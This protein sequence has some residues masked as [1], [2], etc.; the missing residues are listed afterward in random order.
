ME[1]VICGDVGF[2]KTEV[3]I[4]AAFKAVQDASQVAVLVPTTVLAEQHYETFSGRLSPFPV[5]VAMLSRF[6]SKAEQKK[7][8][9]DIKSGAVDIVI[10]THRLLQKDISFK[11]LGLLIIDEEHRFGVK[12]KEKIKSLKKNVDV[13]LLSATPIPRTLSLALS[14]LR[15]LSVIETPPYGRLPIET[16]LGPTD[17]KTIKKVIQAEL[18]R[19]GQVFYVH[20]RV[21]TIFSRAEYLSKLVPGH[22]NR[23][24]ARPAFRP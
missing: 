9:A 2:G 12:Q 19:G 20:N 7:V 21:E 5:K 15:D 3:A 17:E 22:K 24:C 10:G 8:V 23:R 14:N 16:H 1:R 18:A 4:R 6:Q 13:L 11:N